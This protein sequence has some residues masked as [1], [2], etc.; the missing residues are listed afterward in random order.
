MHGPGAHWYAIIDGAQDPRLTALVQQCRTRLCLF[1]GKLDPALE[2]AA[3]WLVLIDQNEPLLPTWQQ[4]GRGA[5]WG[6]M[7]L[8][9]LD[10][11]DLRRHFRKF[12]Q[13]MLPDGL[14]ALF[15]FYDPRV[16]NT[17]LRSATPE[18]RVP[19]FEGVLQYGVET[20]G[21]QAM[22]QYRCDNGRLIDGDRYIG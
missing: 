15:R 11:E 4:H 13:A 19:W 17:Y 22:H 8:S 2:A 21:G 20:E 7:V 14:V 10:I 16:F 18:E 3:P 9:P 12:L 6:I 1:K 5:N